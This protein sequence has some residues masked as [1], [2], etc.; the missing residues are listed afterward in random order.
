MASHLYRETQKLMFHSVSIAIIL[1]LVFLHRD[2]TGPVRGDLSLG[3]W[4]SA[5]CEQAVQSL[6]IVTA[7]LPYAK[8][9][10]Q[11]LDS[12]MIRI[13]DTR[14]RGENYSKGSIG[15]AYELLDIS[16]DGTKRMQAVK[17]HNIGSENTSNTGISQTKT[18][19][20]EREL[21]VE[22][23]FS[24]KDTLGLAISEAEQ[25]PSS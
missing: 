19:T 2:Y 8:M 25:H 14:R 18:W 10:M 21:A 22:G 5:V 20:V 12:G 1:H 23:E 4:R 13:D 6:A 3:Y 15:R 24:P 9:F 11:G 7:S 16:S 17:R